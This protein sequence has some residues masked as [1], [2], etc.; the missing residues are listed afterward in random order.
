MLHHKKSKTERIEKRKKKVSIHCELSVRSQSKV[1]KE[2]KNCCILQLKSQSKCCECI[3][4]VE[5]L[6][7][8]SCVSCILH[9]H[10]LTFI[11][12]LK[13]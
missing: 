8:S 9:F 3:K 10:K 13:C 11:G 7:V 2:E 5:K 12:M 6:V 4:Y 1:K